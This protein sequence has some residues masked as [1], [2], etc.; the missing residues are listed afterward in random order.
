MCQGFNSD[1]STST[2]HRQA[3]FGTSLENIPEGDGL[4]CTATDHCLPSQGGLSGP[5]FQPHTGSSS[6]VSGGDDGA[7]R[8]KQKQRTVT[9]VRS[10]PRPQQQPSLSLP[11]PGEEEWQLA[12][13][14]QDLRCPWGT[15]EITGVSAGGWHPS[16]TDGT[17]QASRA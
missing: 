1:V 13:G 16:V 7:R 9:A 10:Q 12:H 8:Q 5:E 6:R 17:G 2:V 15:A 11:A 14:S 4:S 3:C